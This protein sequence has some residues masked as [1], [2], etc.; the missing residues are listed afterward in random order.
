M[1]KKAENTWVLEVSCTVTF[2][3]QNTPGGSR[4]VHKPVLRRGL[5]RCCG[6]SGEAEQEL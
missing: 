6:S 1:F 4:K 5:K 2:L 3:I